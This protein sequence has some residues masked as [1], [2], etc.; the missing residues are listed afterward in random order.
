[1]CSFVLDIAEI[2]PALE[3]CACVVVLEVWS[4]KQVM[5]CRSPGIIQTG[6]IP[7]CSAEANT[8]LSEAS[9]CQVM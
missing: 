3:A 1:M 2:S 4:N 5:T 6:V 9:E 8:H 7:L